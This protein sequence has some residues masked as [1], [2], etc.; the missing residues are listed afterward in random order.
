MSTI[1]DIPGKNINK[2]VLDFILDGETNETNLTNER[3][4]TR[5][6]ENY[7]FM[8]DTISEK[9]SSEDVMNMLTAFDE[10]FEVAEIDFDQEH[11]TNKNEMEI[12]EDLNS[13]GKPLSFYELI[14]N[15]LFNMCSEEILVTHEEE[16]VDYFNDSFI[17]PKT[18]KIML[19][20]NIEKE[21]ENFLESYIHYETSEEI[22]TNAKEKNA[23]DL[24]GKALKNN[25]PKSDNLDMK[26]YKEIVDHLKR[27][28]DIYVSVRF[29]EMNLPF[30]IYTGIKKAIDLLDNK[31]KTPIYPMIYLIA[32]GLKISNNINQNFS[33]T[34]MTRIFNSVLLLIQPL[35]KNMYIIG[36][37]DSSINR[38]YYEQ[39][40]KFR[41]G[42]SINNA[43]KNF[44]TFKE[45]AQ[46]IDAEVG[47]DDRFKMHIMAMKK[48]S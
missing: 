37:G 19:E 41:A 23:L 34:D 11:T 7:K 25:F 29:S 13:K 43:E 14:K 39:I 32:D 1:F 38:K 35:I 42:I 5:Y 26:E 15:F 48:T 24:I 20:K 46:A 44:L 21:M 22:T 16:I 33:I 12:F 28:F 17:F 30:V 36:Q 8:Y 4:K 45:I 2:K 31:K 47:T 9:K 6:Y 27:Y 10:C 18:P 40:K 3:K